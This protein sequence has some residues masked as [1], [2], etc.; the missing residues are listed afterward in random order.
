MKGW[1]RHWRTR[2]RH[3]R[4]TGL[5]P[6]ESSHTASRECSVRNEIGKRLSKSE[7]RSIELLLAQGD[8]YAEPIFVILSPMDRATWQLLKGIRGLAYPPELQSDFIQ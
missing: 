8:C 3:L 4:A 5:G 6:A 2:Q 1:R 7:A